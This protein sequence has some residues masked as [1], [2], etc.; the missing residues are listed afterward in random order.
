M[1]TRR[2][3]SCRRRQASGLRRFRCAP[4]ASGPTALRGAWQYAGNLTAHN[5]VAID[6]GARRD[7]PA[8]LSETPVAILGLSRVKKQT[9]GQFWDTAIVR[10]RDIK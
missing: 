8:T 5:D 3:M 4:V 2:W 10:L 9:P 7:C 6:P 1:V